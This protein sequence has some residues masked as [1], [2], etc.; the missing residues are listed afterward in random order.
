[1]ARMVLDATTGNENDELA[2]IVGDVH[3]E[4]R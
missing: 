3:G 2:E 1:M 4:S